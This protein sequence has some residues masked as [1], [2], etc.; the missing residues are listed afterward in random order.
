MAFLKVFLLAGVATCG[1]LPETFGVER[2]LFVVSLEYTV[3]QL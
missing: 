1:E 3:C 2:P